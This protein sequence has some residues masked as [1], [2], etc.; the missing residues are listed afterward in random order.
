MLSEFNS[1]FL[2]NVLHIRFVKYCQKH[3]LWTVIPIWLKMFTC[4]YVLYSKWF[5]YHLRVIEYL[6][7][8]IYIGLC[9]FLISESE[10]RKQNTC[11][12]RI[13]I[14]VIT[15]N[16]KKY[17]YRKIMILEI[18][19]ISV[20]KRTIWI[21]RQGN[22]FEKRVPLM[23]CNGFIW[24]YITTVDSLFL[25]RFNPRNKRTCFCFVGTSMKKNHF[26]VLR[27]PI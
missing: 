17:I 14:Y 10:T 23:I 7:A 24:P 6:I 11:T 13:S 22:R 4:V 18:V 19:L 21:A 1:L 16:C 20:Q 15:I 25:K 5:I 27:F 12:R 26:N 8:F 9:F 3:V 2:F